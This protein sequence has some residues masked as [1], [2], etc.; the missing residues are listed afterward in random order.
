MANSVP[1]R[2]RS[3][4]GDQLTDSFD[5]LEAQYLPGSIIRVVAKDDRGFIF[6]IL[7]NEPKKG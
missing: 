6:Q 7:I 1:D 3:A 5:E 4:L 2:I